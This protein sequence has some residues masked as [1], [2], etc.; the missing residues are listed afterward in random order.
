MKLRTRRNSIRL[1]LSRGEVATFAERGEV[2]ETITFGPGPDAR[3]TYAVV[4]SPT[5]AAIGARIEGGAI[6]VE[7]PSAVARAFVEPDRVG[8]EGAQPT[9]TAEDA[10]T[11]LL[12]KDFACL[13]PRAG[14]DDADAFPNPRGREGSRDG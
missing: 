13:A 12:E 9:G 6:V 14:E 5:A 7:V 10:L 11:I 8:V 4:A 3:L 2:R 1:R